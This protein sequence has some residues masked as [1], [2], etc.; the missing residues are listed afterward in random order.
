MLTDF[1]TVGS[2]FWTR[3]Q[4]CVFDGGLALHGAILEFDLHAVRVH[5]NYGATY[6]ATAS[7]LY[8]TQR[9]AS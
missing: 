9:A 8:W 1:A 7:A 4:Q 6:I 2:S 3:Q 5:D